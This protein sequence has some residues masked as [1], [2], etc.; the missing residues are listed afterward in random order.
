MRIEEYLRSL[1]GETEAL[2]NRVR[3]LIEDAHW[4]TD[5]EWKESVIRQILRRYLPAS[6]SVCRGFVVT[7][8][9]SSNQL[10]ILICDSSKPVLFRDGDLAFV[11]PDAVMG[12]IEVKSRVSPTQFARAAEKLGEDTRIIRSSPNSNAFAGIFSFEGNGGNSIAFL[13]AV[14]D[15]SPDSMNRVDFASIGTSRFIRYWHFDPADERH[16][17]E[18]W[19]SYDL[20]DT[21]P[22]YFVH[23]IVDAISPESVLRNNDLWFPSGGKE[24]FK[25][26]ET[27][28][29][30]ATQRT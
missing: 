26:G 9:R 5:G 12:V 18:G 22:G 27:L 29:L 7:A 14:R 8:N 20:P 30:W 24:G 21:A 19:H 4:Q 15:A 10:D 17:Y 11:S 13:A 6:V 23:N 2:K 28:G 25:D 3:Y 16:F 1:T